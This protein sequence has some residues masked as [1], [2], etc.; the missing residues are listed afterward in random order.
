MF[1]QIKTTSIQVQF[2]P[3]CRF[4]L[5]VISTR[6]AKIHTLRLVR[7]ALHNLPAWVMW[8]GDYAT[9]KVEV[10]TATAE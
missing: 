4:I 7:F 2:M 10:M 8:R 6:I 9:Y 5:I 3:K 1:A